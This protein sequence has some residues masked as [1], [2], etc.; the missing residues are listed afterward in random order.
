MQSTPIE[1]PTHARNINLAETVQPATPEAK[2]GT[3]KTMSISAEVASCA[4][5][6]ESVGPEETHFVFVLIFFGGR[7]IVLFVLDLFVVF[8]VWSLGFW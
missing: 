7:Y 5:A 6:A 8:G 2:R 3:V 4:T 1:S